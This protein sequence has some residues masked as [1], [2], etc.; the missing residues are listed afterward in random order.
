MLQWK[1]GFL[2]I[3][4]VLKAKQED[5]HARKLSKKIELGKNLF[6]EITFSKL[7]CYAVDFC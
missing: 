3:Q 6:L 4:C 1:V 5:K 7:S 2:V